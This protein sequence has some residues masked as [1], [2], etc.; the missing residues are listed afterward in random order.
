MNY[1]CGG[2]Y[3]GTASYCAAGGGYS[4]SYSTSGSYLCNTASYMGS[5]YSTKAEYTMPETPSFQ[6]TESFLTE[7]RPLTPMIS[8]LGEIKDIIHQTFQ[9]I[10]GQDFPEDAIK[11]KICDEKQFRQF[12]PANVL[13]IS[14][15]K[16]GKGISEIIAVQDHMDR[17]LLTIGH[18]IGHVLSPTLPNLKDEEAKA[19][20]F[21]IA[22][23]ETIRENNIGGLRPNI[24]PNPAHNGIHDAAFDFVKYLMQTGT[25][26]FDVFKTLAYGLTS[27]IAR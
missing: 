19:H 22:W 23:I 9:K 10:T 8:N 5:S 14:Y 13:G 20:A 1:G 7:N 18:E 12:Q 27:M 25:S 26:A 6:I 15:N 11:I 4:Q 24:I 3:S 21:S 16:Y 17:L 2:G